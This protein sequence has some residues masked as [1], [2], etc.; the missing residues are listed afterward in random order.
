MNDA[1]ILQTAASCGGGVCNELLSM[2]IPSAQKYAEKHHCDYRVEFGDIVPDITSDKIPLCKLHM[3]MDVLNKYR[4]IAYIDADAMIINDYEDFRTIF[5]E[6][7]FSVG[8]VEY[9]DPILHLNSGVMYLHVNTE[10]KAFMKEL[11]D[12]PWHTNWNEQGTVNDMA[13]EVSWKH[14]IGAIDPIWNDWVGN[15]KSKNPIVRGFHGSQAV[16]IKFKMMI[17]EMIKRLCVMRN[18]ALLV[19]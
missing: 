3:I 9:T 1:I 6:N 10:S 5:S 16:D 19:N 13:K 7:T 11:I 2:S 15:P 12:R 4:Y 14:I 8:F 18:G 17:S